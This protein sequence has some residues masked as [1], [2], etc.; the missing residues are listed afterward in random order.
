MSSSETS[1][2]FEAFQGEIDSAF[3]VIGAD[4]LP[5]ICQLERGAGEVGKLLA[6]GVAVSAEI[7]DQVADG[8]RGVMAVAEEIVESLVASDGLILAEGGQEIGES[9]FGNVEFAD[10][11][12]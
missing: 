4:V 1:E 8:I 11:S 5:E 12:G 7:E 6:L 10:G 3:V 2:L 9:L